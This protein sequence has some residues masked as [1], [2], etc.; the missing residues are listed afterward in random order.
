MDKI[1][2]LWECLTGDDAPVTIH[3]YNEALEHYSEV[4]NMTLSQHFIKEFKN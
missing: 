2:L 3:E 4:F 1:E